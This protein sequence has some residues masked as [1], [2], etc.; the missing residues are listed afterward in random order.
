MAS[1]AV[2]KL[3]NGIV[4]NLITDDA[5]KVLSAKQDKALEDTKA[6]TETNI[7]EI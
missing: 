4:D 2:L 3:N 7:G 6:E 1:K 5:I